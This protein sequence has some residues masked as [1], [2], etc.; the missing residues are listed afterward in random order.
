MAPLKLLS[1][2][3]LELMS[4]RLLANLINAVLEAL[5]KQIKVDLAKYW[6]DSKTALF[7]LQNN[8]EWKEF[9]RHRVNE[10]LSRTRK[11]DWGHVPGTEN[12]ADLGSRGVLA[13]L[14]KNSTLW[15]EGPSWLKEDEGNWRRNFLIEDSSEV[16][17][18]RKK[19]NVMMAVQSEKR[20]ASK[21]I[22]IGR[23][24]SLFRL[25]RGTA[26]AL[27]FTKNLKGKKAKRDT[28]INRLKVEEI[29][30]AE[31][32][33]IEDAQDTIKERA[34]FERLSRQVGIVNNENG[35]LVC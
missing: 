27:R 29:E 15:W 26:F 5:D 23:Y 20:G 22:K 25:L 10:I 34:D 33:W 4:A 19:T 21:V 11:E 8:G 9:I 28:D 35:L 24:G 30:H 3:R 18:E 12:S 17:D 6:L 14:L 31:K 7:W 16:E 32:V 13:S 2:P 1:I